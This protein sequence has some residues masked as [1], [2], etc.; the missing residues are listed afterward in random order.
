[1]NGSLAIFLFS[2]VAQSAVGPLGANLQSALTK[3]DTDSSTGLTQYGWQFNANNELEYLIQISPEMLPFMTSTTNQKE[4]Q[5]EIPKELVGRIRRV[6]VSIGTQVLPRSPSLQEVQAMVPSIATLPGRMRELEPG[7]QV[8]NVNNNQYPEPPTNFGGVPSVSGNPNSSVTAVPST[9]LGGAFLDQA[10]AGTP[11]SNPNPGKPSLPTAA[12]PGRF[13]D[14]AG[15]QSQTSQAGGISA[16]AGQSVPNN[17]GWQAPGTSVPLANDGFDRARMAGN[18]PNGTPQWPG[19]SNDPNALKYS[20]TNS[21]INNNGVAG[22]LPYQS[23]PVS[24]QGYGQQPPNYAQ[25]QGY[26]AQTGYGQNA[27]GGQRVQTGNP[28]FVQQGQGFNLQGS[29]YPSTSGGFGDVVGNQGQSISDRTRGLDPWGNPVISTGPV[30]RP[31]EP[32]LA[33]RERDLL[34]ATSGRISPSDTSASSDPMRNSDMTR[35]ADLSDNPKGTTPIESTNYSLFVF[36]VLSVAVNLWMVHLLRSLYLRYRNLLT[37][38]RS[39]TA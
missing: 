35:N 13:S 12:P 22:S 39:Q 2:L 11:Q 6:V 17:N 30:G 34:S 1:M 5:S 20:S 24:N 27:F 14:T 7:T 8:T 9:P 15:S 23:Q 4:F 10:R 32:Y 37:S 38:L 26:D 33:S 19:A 25:Q 31:G 18:Q 36:F 29:T 21:G 28:G 3:S 16:Q